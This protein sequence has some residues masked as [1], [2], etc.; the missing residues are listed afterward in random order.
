MTITNSQLHEQ[1]KV[2]NVSTLSLG[3]GPHNTVPKR[4]IPVPTR[5][6][7]LD[8]KTVDNYFTVHAV[9]IHFSKTNRSAHSLSR[10]RWLFLPISR[11]I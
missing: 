8:I 1:G 9:M 10:I 11:Y 5:N 4:T 3:C 6:Q 7:I 2:I